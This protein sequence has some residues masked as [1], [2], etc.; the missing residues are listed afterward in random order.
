MTI[1]G[2][3]TNLEQLELTSGGVDLVSAA[4]GGGW[5]RRRQLVLRPGEGELT[6][7]R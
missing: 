6:Y 2:Y 1:F 7:E 5:I 4:S 3:R